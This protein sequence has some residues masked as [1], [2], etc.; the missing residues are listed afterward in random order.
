MYSRRRLIH[1]AYL[2]TLFLVLADL[3]ALSQAAPR[4]VDLTAADG[5]PLKAT[6]FASDKPGPAVL[7]LHQCDAERKLWN[8]LGERMAA[9]GI[10]VL[11]LDYRGFGESGGARYDKMT[12]EERRKVTTQYWPAD[13]E[14]AH[15]Y[16]VKQHEVQRDKIGAGGASC[17]VDNAIQLARR[18]AEI[19]SLM[20]LSGPTNRD[21]RLFLTS[22]KLPIF[23]AAA[24]DD[25]YPGTVE[26]VQ[27]LYGASPN[28]A[29][30]FARFPNGGHGAEMFAPHPELVTLI[31]EW[32]NATLR[33]NPEKAP[34]TQ[35]EG[36]D[37]RQLAMLEQI[38][39][40]GGAAQV[41]S[42]LGSSL[43][44]DSKSAQFPEVFV[45]QLGYEHV[46]L[47]DTKGAVEIMKLNTIAFPDSPNAYD[48][49]SDAY[50]ADG[51]KELA[52][53]TAKKAIDLLKRNTTDPEPRRNAIRDSAEQKVKQLEVKH[54]EREAIER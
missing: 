33:G 29:S 28:P 5:T 16:L 1:G 18:H 8:V 32:F 40:P 43:D 49:L 26:T 4:I 48:S 50:L 36:M 39:R 38:D 44:R 2:L 30:R 6:Y 3:A 42:T 15:A 11:T 24:N 54:L 35:G 19:K 23:T 14:M 31:T 47:G 34:K 9:S 51:Q 10:S 17:G 37:P 20:L 25:K 21:G 41:A 45:N 7:L 13:I 22:S 53:Q 27:W 46:Q 52:L 12:G